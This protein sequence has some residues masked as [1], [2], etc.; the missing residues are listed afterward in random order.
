MK[1]EV[2][3]VFAPIAVTIETKEELEFI[4]G[5]LGKVGGSQT[6]ESLFHKLAEELGSDMHGFFVGELRYVGNRGEI[7]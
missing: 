1:I 7:I 5:A 4:V 6:I 2:D 3:K